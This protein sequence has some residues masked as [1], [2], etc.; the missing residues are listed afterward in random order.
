[1]GNVTAT[2]DQP[3]TVV[4]H[5][6]GNA[7]HEP[8]ATYDAHAGPAALYAASW[9][10]ASSGDGAW[11]DAPWFHAWSDDAWTN[12]PTG[13]LSFICN[14]MFDYLPV[15]FILISTILTDRRK[16]SQSHPLPHQPARGDKRAHALDALQPVSNNLLSA[17]NFSPFVVIHFFACL[18]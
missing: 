4:L 1:M 18:T 6:S 12:A 13:M 11:S 15:Y 9:H 17:F 3:V 5:F 14:N 8:G 16:S 7:G 10:D 2:T